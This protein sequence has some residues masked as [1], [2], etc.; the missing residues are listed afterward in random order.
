MVSVCGR[1]L[2]MVSVCVC[3]GGLIHGVSVWAGDYLYSSPVETHIP[4]GKLTYEPNQPRDDCVESVLCGCVGVSGHA[5][6]GHTLTG[7]LLSYKG[8]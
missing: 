5:L 1:G 6:Y 2:Y 4:V 3:E 8:E 7:H